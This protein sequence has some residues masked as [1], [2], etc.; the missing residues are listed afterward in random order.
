MF[1]P[2][3]QGTD[4]RGDMDRHETDLWTSQY[5]LV[6]D[7]CHCPAVQEHMP[8]V[9]VLC[10]SVPQAVPEHIEILVCSYIIYCGVFPWQT[11]FAA[12]ESRNVDTVAVLGTGTCQFMNK[13]FY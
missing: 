3:V 10:L 4:T 9:R 8:N 5:L 2:H 7:V 1:L 12:A 6:L 11:L 13:H